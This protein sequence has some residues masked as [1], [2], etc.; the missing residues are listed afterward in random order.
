MILIC[1]LMYRIYPANRPSD[2]KAQAYLRS[3]DSGLVCSRKQS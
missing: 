2:G 1:N 3:K